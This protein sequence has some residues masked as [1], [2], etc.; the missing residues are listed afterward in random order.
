VAIAISSEGDVRSIKINSLQENLKIVYFVILRHFSQK[1]EAF[2]LFFEQFYG[3]LRHY[4]ADRRYCRQ[5][6]VS[7]RHFGALS[8]KFF[9]I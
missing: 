4:F 7:C 1:L 6:A 3:K 2:N 8:A 5:D 9:Y